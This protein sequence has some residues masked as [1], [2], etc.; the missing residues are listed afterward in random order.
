MAGESLG[1]DSSM[2]SMRSNLAKS[3]MFGGVDAEGRA[4]MYFPYE[5]IR[6]VMIPDRGKM[7]SGLNKISKEFNDEDTAE[8]EDHLP[9][10]IGHLYADGP[11]NME[12]YYEDYHRISDDMEQ[13]LTPQWESLD[14]HPIL[15]S[16]KGGDEG[17]QASEG[18]CGCQCD[19][20]Q[21]CL[22]KQELLPP[23]NYVVAV[24]DDIYRR[25][26]S[27][28]ADAQNMP[29][30]LFFCGHHE[31]VDYPSVW[32]PGTL[33]LILFGFMFYVSFYM[34]A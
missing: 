32:I 17:R 18:M 34:E 6:L 11:A 30:G 28:V 20:C 1:A 8:Q 33:V 4:I 29:C 31:D 23:T 21:A 26:F 13:G 25:M 24:S 14:A 2:V 19:N 5:A 9:L 10:T 16:R 15:K 3:S 12:D 7:N 22:G 27:E